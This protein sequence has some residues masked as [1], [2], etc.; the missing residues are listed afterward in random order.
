MGHSS[1]HS[2]ECKQ[3][4]GRQLFCAGHWCVPG[5]RLVPGK[6]QVLSMNEWINE[7]HTA[8]QCCSWGLRRLQSPCPL[9][10]YAPP[11]CGQIS[12]SLHCT[13]ASLILPVPE[14]NPGTPQTAWHLSGCFIVESAFNNH[15]VKEGKRWGQ[16]EGGR[17]ER[18]ALVGG[19][20]KV[21]LS[22]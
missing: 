5:P 22:R 10:S 13:A 2:Q 9:W 7:L 6:E 16:R 11:S 19:S 3:P 17:V 12:G 4:E 8:S 1:S 14:G 18:K 15:L 21:T 20:S